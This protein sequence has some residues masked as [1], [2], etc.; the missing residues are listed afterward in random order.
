MTATAVAAVS[1][2][3]R[4]RVLVPLAGLAAAAALAVG[5][6]ADFTSNSVNS[7]NAYTTGTLTQANS[8]ANSAIFALDNLKPGDTLNGT[9]TI[10]NSGSLP[11]TFKLSETATNGFTTKSNLKLTITEAGSATPVWS[12]TFG[13][14][15]TAGPKD[16]GT[17]EA[18]AA[19]TFVFSV[20]LAQSA[21][22]TEQGKT[23]TAT[24][25]WNAVQTAAV[26]HDR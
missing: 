19:K 6:G 17:W 2:P 9:V 22:N 1:R 8:K 21:D 12:G 4:Y 14:L 23:A 26:T 10:T 24:Y 18:G 16:L 11:A 7:A 5:S 3:R 15:T 20:T 13:D 25:S